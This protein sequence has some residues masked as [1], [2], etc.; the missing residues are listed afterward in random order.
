MATQEPIYVP[1]P[2]DM[3]GLDCIPQDEDPEGECYF[4]P[5]DNTQDG[6]S[7][8]EASQANATQRLEENLAVNEVKVP[9]AMVI[10]SEQPFTASE[11]SPINPISKSILLMTSES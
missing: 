7:W 3:V 9:A 11:M 8:A 5:E 6:V 4:G 1:Q 2:E 10:G